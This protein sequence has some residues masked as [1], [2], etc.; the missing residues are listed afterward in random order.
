MQ[1]FLHF[2]HKSL[3][4]QRKVLLSLQVDKIALANTRVNLF[5]NYLN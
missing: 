3:G 4:L 5:A 2:L 1:P